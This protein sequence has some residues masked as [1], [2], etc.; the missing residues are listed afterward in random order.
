[1]KRRFAL[2]GGLSLATTEPSRSGGAGDYPTD[3]LQKGL[4]L[5]DGEQELGGEGVGFGVPVLKRGARAV[6][7]GSLRT[8]LQDTGTQ[9]AADAP[10]LTL[11]YR[12]DKVER[13][14]GRERP[15]APLAPLDLVR[16]SLSLV[17]RRVPPLRRPLTAVSTAG[18]RLLRVSTR[19]EETT[20]LAEVCVTYS[21]VAAADGSG[22]GL[23][24]TADLSG[25]PPSVTEV[26]LMNEL[27][28]GCFDL[29]EEDDRTERSS[30]IGA[31]DRVAAASARFR[32]SASGVW[33]ELRSRPDPAAPGVRLFRG[34][35]V[36][37][38]R[39]A[40]AG[41]GYS[42]RPGPATFTYTVRFGRDDAVRDDAVRA[43]E[44]LGTVGARA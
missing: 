39:L 22:A 42:L 9:S 36:A 40:W 7:P 12:L 44:A 34:R 15:C 28:A 32:S 26:V 30:G 21:L 13:I 1:V 4:L 31:W 24:V 16:E 27:G 25:L 35:E 33:F 38:G 5:L 41:F 10:S 3:G 18:R 37:P 17:Y 6:F 19:F 29:Y 23:V 2:P 14:G 11:T 20:V 43:A 8:V